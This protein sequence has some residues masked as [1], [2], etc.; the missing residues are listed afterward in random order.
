VSFA[1]RKKGREIAELEEGPAF[2]VAEGD[3]WGRDD[4][5][6]DDDEGAFGGDDVVVTTGET[7]GGRARGDGSG[8]AGGNGL[9]LAKYSTRTG[10]GPMSN[11]SSEEEAR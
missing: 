2:K 5:G 4:E 6:A 10:L 11:I 7:K 8:V 3:G 1:G 9:A